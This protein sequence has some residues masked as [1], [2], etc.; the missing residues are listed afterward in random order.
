M[1]I[2]IC[3]SGLTRTFKHCYQSLLDNVIGPYD[4]DVFWFVEDDE[5]SEDT[6]LIKS[7]RKQLIKSPLHDEKDWESRKRKMRTPIQGFLHQLWKTK[8]CNE[9]MLKYQEDNGMKYDWVIRSRPDLMFVKKMEDLSSLD[10][11]I[12]HI[13]VPGFLKRRRNRLGIFNYNSINCLPDQFAISSHE[14]MTIYAKRYDE[15]Q[16]TIDFNGYLH[17]EASMCAH[18]RVNNITCNMMKP[19]YYIPYRRNYN[20][21]MEWDR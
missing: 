8:M 4:C 9:L 21:N 19:I 3:L 16:K 1:K 18:L 12:L 6:N 14:I 15:L 13:P 20:W 2:A 10:N 5:N 17:P 11:K 7:V